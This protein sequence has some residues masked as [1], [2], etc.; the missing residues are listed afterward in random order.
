VH[1]QHERKIDQPRHRRDIAQQVEGK[2]VEQRHVDRGRRPDEED[3]V[4]VGRRIGHCLDRDVGAGAGLVLDD[5][6]L[7]EPLRQPP[8]HD[9]RYGVGASTRGNPTTQR[10]GCDG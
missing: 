2:I 6:R 10:S 3:R 4:A 8:R 1:D 5:D 7:P 9:P